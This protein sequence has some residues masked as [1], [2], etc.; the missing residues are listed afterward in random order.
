MAG[1]S[2]RPAPA[3]RR[4]PSARRTD[5]KPARRW[6]LAGLFSA[7][8]IVAAAA[9]VTAVFHSGTPGSDSPAATSGDR[10]IA[11]E[12]AI[13]S[14]AVN[15]ITSQVGHNIV[16]A[17]DAVV[18]SALAQQGFPAGNLNVLQPTAP[19]PYGSE[20]LVA[21]ADVRSQFGTKLASVYAP[22]SIAS[23]GTGANRIDVQVIAQN[24]PAAFRTAL[25]KD[26]LARRSSGAELLRNSRI[27]IAPAARS[28]LAA[29]DVD[30][31]LETALAF[32]A[33]QQPLDIL[34]F[35]TSAPGAG[36][37]VPQ[38]FV[39]LAE[40]DPASRLP[41]GRY[42]Q[43][44]V[45]GAKGLRPPYVPMSAEAV[46]LPNGHLALRIEFPAPSLLGLLSY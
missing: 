16:V 15:W 43:S 22:E 26:L 33:T 46:R 18:C 36:A 1:P 2:V 20:L 23:F 27:A 12:A 10:S 38:R 21:T 8:A 37:G 17:C 13:R 29:G 32:L 3:D 7:V 5:G 42:L 28:Q 25:R 30:L 11:S 4:L 24:G 39:Y 44:L 9:L 41:A 35:G 19:D 14:Q 6:R 45:A 34:G 40:T 31:R